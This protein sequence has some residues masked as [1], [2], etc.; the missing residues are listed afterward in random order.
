M[1]AD[2]GCYGMKNGGYSMPTLSAFIIEVMHAAGARR[3]GQW[4]S[5]FN[6][7][8][9]RLCEAGEPSLQHS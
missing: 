6:E 2:V 9:S 4:D 1:S 7:G 8:V 3:S 5:D